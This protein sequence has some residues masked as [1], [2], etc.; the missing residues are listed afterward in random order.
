MEDSAGDPRIMVP[1]YWESTQATKG[2]VGRAAASEDWEPPGGSACCCELP[3]L[4]QQGQQYSA[5][6][7][8]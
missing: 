8:L 3:F 7:Q 4:Q 6:S 1:Y 5:S 2:L